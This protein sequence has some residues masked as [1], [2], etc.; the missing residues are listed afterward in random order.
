MEGSSGSSWKTRTRTASAIS[1]LVYSTSFIAFTDV[2]MDAKTPNLIELSF[3]PG[4]EDSANTNN[5]IVISNWPSSGALVNT[6]F[7]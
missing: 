1:R 6:F 2:F 4:S 7:Q 3:T 5:K